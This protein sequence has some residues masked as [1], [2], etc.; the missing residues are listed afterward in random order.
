MVLTIFYP[1][2]CNRTTFGMLKSLETPELIYFLLNWTSSFVSLFLFIIFL[3]DIQLDSAMLFHNGD[4]RLCRT[5]WT[6][7][8]QLPNKR[9]VSALTK[10]HHFDNL[11]VL[12]R[13]KFINLIKILS[14]ISDSG[15]CCTTNN[16]G[17]WSCQAN[18]FLNR[19][20]HIFFRPYCDCWNS[21]STICCLP[22][23]SSYLV[24][25]LV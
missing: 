16:Q 24:C 13:T 20:N 6:C 25:H 23:N 22:P 10:F 9:L 19:R 7:L 11:L 3:S 18:S 5:Y 15:R 2:R 4:F 17:D 12:W 1:V 14:L 21:R 8:G